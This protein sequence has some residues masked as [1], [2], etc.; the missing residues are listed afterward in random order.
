MK[1]LFSILL[2]DH[3]V[4]GRL[5]YLYLLED[6]GKGYFKIVDRI[7]PANISYYQ[8][9]LTGHLSNVVAETEQYSDGNLKQRFSNKKISPRDFII[10]LDN[11]YVKSYVRPF[12]EKRIASVI[13]LA[14]I[15]K[16]RVF[17]R[18]N[19]EV[20]Y[21][22]DEI[23]VEPE[24]AGIVFNFEK[25]ESDT[26]YFQTIQHCGE[27]IYLTSKNGSILTNEPC[28]LLLENKLYHFEESVD[29]KK[30]AVFF[31]KE[32]IQVPARLEGDFY[33]TFIKNS[34][35]KFPVHVK[36]FKIENVQGEKKASLSYELDLSGLPA[37]VLKYNYN[38]K[39]ILPDNKKRR[40]VLFGESTGFDFQ[41]VHRD[42]DWENQTVET[43]KKLGLSCKYENYFFPELMSGDQYGLIGWL[44]SNAQHLLDAGIEV[45]QDFS[46]ISYFT[47]RIKMDISYSEQNDW[48]D[49]YA[50]AKFGDMFEIPMFKLRKYL[51]NGIREYELPDGQIAILPEQ[52]FEKYEDLVSFGQGSQ[53]KI[54][55]KK[56]HFSLVEQSITGKINVL[57]NA[58]KIKTS[59]KSD[60]KVDLPAG[61]KANLRSYQVEGFKWLNNMRQMKLGAC[62]ADDMGLGKTLQTLSILMQHISEKN[63]EQ[64]SDSHESSGQLDL[65]SADNKNGNSSPSIVIMPASLLHNWEDEIKKFTPAIKYLRYTGQ[66]RDEMLVK[67]NKVDLVLTTYGTIRNDID[68]LEKR[69]FEY[70]ILDESQVIKNPGSKIARSVQKLQS[71]HRINL[72]GTPIENSLIDLWSQMNF[73][74]K[75][76]LGD[77]TF[78]KR[79]FAKPI[80]KN[81]NAEKQEKLQ[82]LI[83]PFILRRTKSQVEKELPELNEEFVYCEMSDEQKQLYLE[84]KSRIRNHILQSI[85]ERGLKKSGVTI[86]QGLSKL[87]QMANHPRMVI[88]E[89]KHESGKFDEI[90]HKL[91]TLISEGHK[92]LL[93]SS[94][95]KHLSI[96]EEY[97]ISSQTEYSILTG[98]STRRGKVIKEFQDDENKKV[99]LISMKAG[100]VGLN[101]TQADYVFLLDPW[102]NPAVENQAVNRAHRIGQKRHVFA[103]RFISMG[104]IEEKILKLQRKKSKLADIFIRSDS[105]LNKL[106]IENIKELID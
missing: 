68:D 78:F 27:Q 73:L 70:L 39:V 83:R 58:Q 81:N 43:L 25:L 62:L 77:L 48:F 84:E 74:N 33:S 89:Y 95:V 2:Q 103:Y 80:E 38:N 87:R 60:G 52:W 53:N 86:L 98:A 13:S 46:D 32:F 96:L 15:S 4:L 99:F 23:I 16:L 28:W 9:E 47:S 30:L 35:E 21:K 41:L 63:G 69:N 14:G 26:R 55:V 82:L 106:S 59:K 19:H 24:P 10:S 94:Y 76:L 100:G 17:I 31:N 56:H 101:L 45:S 44:N 8:S 65:F 72:S 64:E 90:I 37:L 79:Y 6:E 102:W 67:F 11:S 42:F 93:F 1:Q 71:N 57:I 97:L 29:G 36:G 66:Q 88:P 12:I 61:L 75:G 105:P 50:M 92:I 3:P 18:D 91:K 51:L 22:S 34:I 7:S 20:V 85:E 5:A 49:V 104:T 54:R 40:F